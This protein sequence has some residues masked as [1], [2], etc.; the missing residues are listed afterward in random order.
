MEG[1]VEDKAH[2]CPPR[3]SVEGSAAAQIG[4]GKALSSNVGCEPGITSSFMTQQTAMKRF[5]DGGSALL[6]FLSPR[7]T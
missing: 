5:I 6:T 3:S 7:L 2:A 4:R 1:V